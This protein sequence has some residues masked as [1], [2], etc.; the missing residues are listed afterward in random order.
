MPVRLAKNFL[1]GD[2][3]YRVRRAI[4]NVYNT[5]GYGH[6]ESIYQKALVKEFTT[7]AIPYEEEKPLSVYYN[8]EKVGTYRPDFLVD[9]RVVVE[10]KAVPYVT[11]EMEKQLVYYLRGTSY[12]LGMLANFGGSKLAIK[13]L[14]WDVNYR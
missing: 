10:I 14:I 2:L 3:T 7:L 5:L 11:K 4:F 6:R 9:D 12:K 13:R 8:Q 1:Y